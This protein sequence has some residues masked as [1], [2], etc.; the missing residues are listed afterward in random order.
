MP[1]LPRARTAERSCRSSTS[2]SMEMRGCPTTISEHFGS[3]IQMGN[4]TR[5]P[6]DRWQTISLSAKIFAC[7]ATRN[8]SPNNAC[9]R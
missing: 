2:A 3:S 6:S 1:A 5:L 8:F 7:D 4:T 9:Q